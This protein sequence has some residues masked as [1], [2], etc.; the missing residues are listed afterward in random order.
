MRNVE[1]INK[2]IKL[3]LEQKGVDTVAFAE[4]LEVEPALV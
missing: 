1:H 3:I 4:E 2:N